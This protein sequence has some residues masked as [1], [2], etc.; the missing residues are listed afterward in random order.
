M[1]HEEPELDSKM[2]DLFPDASI[3]AEIKKARQFRE[4]FHRRRLEETP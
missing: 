2:K 1:L 3:L 4:N